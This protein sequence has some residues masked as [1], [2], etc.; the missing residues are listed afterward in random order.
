MGAGIGFVAGGVSGFMT[1]DGFLAGA[2]SGAATG[3]LAG[4]TLG[5]SLVVKVVVGSSIAAVGDAVVQG[6]RNG[7]NCINYSQVAV[8]GVNGALAA[9]I[10]GLFHAAYGADSVAQS[11]FG[12]MASGL[13]SML[14]GAMSL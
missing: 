4:L 1:G 7:F 2:A 10:G 13:G 6:V 3:S 12:N 9:S 14:Y 11:F 5:G 8:A